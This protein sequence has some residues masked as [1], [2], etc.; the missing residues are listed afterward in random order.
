MSDW[1]EQAEAY[2]VRARQARLEQ[3]FALS[4]EDP[5]ARQ[6]LQRLMDSSPPDTHKA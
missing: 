3:G 6:R 1:L 5:A 4:V 2:S